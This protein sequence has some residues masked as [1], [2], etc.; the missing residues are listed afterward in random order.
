MGEFTIRRAE[1]R[2]YEGVCR[3]FADESVYSGTLQTPFPSVEQWRK[4]M[5]EPAENDY[6]L[7]ACAGDEIVGHAGLHPTH[8]TPRRAHVMTIGMGIV[9]PWQ[10]RGVG[11]ALV[12]AMMDLA[13]NWLNVFR[14]ELTVYVDNAPAIALYKKFGFEKEG[15]LRAYALRDGRYVDAYFMA[16]LRPKP[17]AV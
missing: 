2:D 5:A 9:A 17:A 4:R 14:I 13:D 7:V 16:R 10:H 8:K 1:P 11:T 12:A 15:T 3:T 6:L